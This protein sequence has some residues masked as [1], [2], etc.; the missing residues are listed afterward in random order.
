[1][2]IDMSDETPEPRQDTSAI[3]RAATAPLER[4]LAV[5]DA[6]LGASD[7]TTASQA[8]SI[9]DLRE[10]V[11]RTEAERD[12]LRAHVAEMERRL[13]EMAAEFERRKRRSF[14]DQLAGWFGWWPTCR[15]RRGRRP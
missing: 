10:R 14:W 5:A 4:R 12:A 6:L 8:A 15:S 11:G 3:I 13:K 2:V 1:V 7:E 9:A